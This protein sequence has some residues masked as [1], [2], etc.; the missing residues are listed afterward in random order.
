[1]KIKLRHLTIA[2]GLGAV[3]GLAAPIAAIAGA[4]LKGVDVKL[5]KNPGGKPAA[6]A[7]KSNESIGSETGAPAAKRKSKMLNPQPEPPGVH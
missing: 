2:F 5:G 1:M 4:P 6:R 3:I 7:V